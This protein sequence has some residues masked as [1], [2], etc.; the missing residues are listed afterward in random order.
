MIENLSQ[1]KRCPN[2]VL[3]GHLPNTIQMR[4]RS[5]CK[6]LSEPASVCCVWNNRRK[7]HV[8]PP[9]SG[10]HLLLRVVFQQHELYV[11][12]ETHQQNKVL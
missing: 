12:I 5:M 8:P 10:S 11:A 7:K 3:P 4:R 2:L 1:D 9:L 6:Q